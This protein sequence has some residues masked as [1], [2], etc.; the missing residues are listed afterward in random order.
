MTKYSRHEH[1]QPG[2]APVQPLD[3]DEL[4]EDLEALLSWHDEFKAR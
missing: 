1:S 4:Q 2:E 3:P